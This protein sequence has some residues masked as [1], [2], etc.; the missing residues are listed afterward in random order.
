MFTYA[1][2]DSLIITAEDS[3]YLIT[4]PRIEVDKLYVD[5]NVIF[6]FS[7]SISNFELN[8]KEAYIGSNVFFNGRGTSRSGANGANGY[9]ANPGGY[10]TDGGHG[11]NGEYGSNGGHGV[12]IT[13]NL[14]IYRMDGAVSIDTSGSN[15]GRGGNGGNGNRGSCTHTC[16]GGHG[17][18]GGN[19]G[20]GGNGGNGGN[21]AVNFRVSSRILENLTEPS[22]AAVS[23][24]NWDKHPEIFF[25]IK[26]EGGQMGENGVRGLGGD[27]GSGR[28]CRD[29]I[30]KITIHTRDP[31][32]DGSDGSISIG[33][34]PSHNGHNGVIDINPI[35]LIDVE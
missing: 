2:D 35:G 19:A 7:P 29:P 6:L 25:Q 13:L 9:Q 26:S 4:Q 21:V 32:H 30:L 5:S 10:C 16:N 17:G 14:N 33:I 23:L 24:E 27:G 12:H 22:E 31:G 3:P 34:P 8:A 20:Y 11:E 1:E 15:G 18:R 28:P